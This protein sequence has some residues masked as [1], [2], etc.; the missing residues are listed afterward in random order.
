MTFLRN[1]LILL[2]TC[3]SLVCAAQTSTLKKI[4][5]KYDNYAYSDA[6]VGYETLI[7][8]GYSTTEVLKRLGNSNYLV[9]NYKEAAKWYEKLV[10]SDD[11][12]SD[13][14]FIY[15]YATTLRSLENYKESDEWMQK[16]QALNTDDQRAI[17]F[18]KNRDYLEDIKSRA[19]T[20]SVNSLSI[21]TT[22][23]DFSP[24]FIPE[25]VLFASARDTGMFSKNIHS[26]NT[27]T[28][29]DLFKSKVTASGDLAEPLKMDKSINKKTHE[30]SPAL[31]PDGTTLYFTRNNSTNGNFSRDS[32]GVSRLKIFKASL[33]NGEWKKVQEL[34]FNGK[35]YSVA[36][37]TVSADGKWLY[38]AS[39]M[40]GTL[41]ASDIFKVAIKEDG[42][43]GEPINL[44]NKINTEGTE[45][46]PFI[47]KEE[48]LFFAS[49]GHPGL[50]GLDMFATKLDQ[51]EPLP[52]INLGTPVNSIEDD[53]S[54][55][56]NSE[57]KQGYFAS[58]R[59]GGQGSDD[60]YGIKQLK[61]LRFECFKD[62]EIIVLEKGSNN[63]LAMA[64]VDVSGDTPTTKTATNKD[65]N[66]VVALDCYT[67]NAIIIASKEG[68]KRSDMKIT[69][70]KEQRQI[71]LYLEPLVTLPALGE[72]LI[73]YLKLEPI[74][75]D[76]DKYNLTPT[77]KNTLDQA[78]A[79]LK[80]YPKVQIEVR[81]HT[82]ALASDA[83]NDKLS[84]RR[85]TTTKAYLVA[86]GIDA[87]R[88]DEKSFGENELLNDCKVWNNCTPEQ[89]HIN[90]RAELIV[91]KK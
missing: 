57:S 41:G 62:L 35:E 73:A 65:G 44:G 87:S 7:K 43:Y 40:P 8:K 82:D 51:E 18:N 17:N 4:D 53:F 30:S 31:S 42:S 86:N 33:I 72:D 71:T 83:Y 70:M 22:E 39:D 52:V 32:E 25:G 50:G 11:F 21:N 75:F 45:S 76:L 54:L 13:P 6:I 38:F 85:A 46:F 49:N 16:F 79:F 91:I 78:L 63:P 3:I 29:L 64:N 23:S 81:A 1:N 60:I 89:N 27:K 69:E 24:A 5:K 36:H 61:P 55:I 88:I 90:R 48:V 9:A 20:F 2:Y 67:T 12:D 58:N 56:L 26:W 34:P 68:Y 19:G 10:T 47:T 28:F 74:L 14:E 37:P 80:A 66:A 15:R 77:A 84:S 59:E